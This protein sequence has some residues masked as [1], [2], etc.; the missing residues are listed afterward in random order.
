LGNNRQFLAQNI[1]G[2]I[3]NVKS[4]NFY[5]SSL[6]F[7]NT[8]QSETDGALAGAS[9]SNDSNFLASL[10]VETET[11]ENKVGLW[12]VPEVHILESDIAV[13]W[14]L[15]FSVYRDF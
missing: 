15:F 3:L 8:T 2:Y 9:P 1:E 12:S 11:F 14:P 6:D 4:V 13:C 7:N 5:G 10:D